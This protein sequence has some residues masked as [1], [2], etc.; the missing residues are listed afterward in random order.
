MKNKYPLP[1]I[2]DLFD[3]MR[4]ARVFSNIDLRSGYHQIKIRPSDFPKADFSTRYGLYEFT[5]MLF[6]LTNAPAHFMNLMNKVFI[7]YLDRFVVV[8]ID[9]IFI[10]SKSDSDHEEHLRLVLQKLRDNQLH[11]KFSKCEFWIG[12]VPFLGH[13]ISNGGISVD[14]AKVKEIVAWSIPTIVTEVQSFLGLAGYYR[15]FIEGLSKNSK[16]MTSLLEKGREFKLDEKCQD[17]FDQLKKRLMSPPVLVMPDLQKGFDIY[18]DACGQG[19]GCVLMQEGH[20]IAYASRQLWKHELNYPTHDLELAAV[21]HA[22]KIWRHYI[23]GT[24]CQ[25]YKYH[26]SLKYIFTRK[27]LNLRQRHWLELIKDY[28][29]EIHYHPGKA[30]LVA[31][32]LSWKEHVHSAIV[33]RLPE[34]LAKDFERLNLGIVTHTEGVTIEL[35]P[36]LEQEI[37]K[38]QIGD[39][40]IQDIKDLITEG[41][42]LDFIEDE[43]GTIWFKNRICVP[44]IDSLRE[45]ILK[46]AHDSVYSIHPGSTKMYQDLKQKYWWCGL[47]RVERCGCTCGYVRWVSKS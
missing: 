10:Y 41:R 9:D 6:G 20:V 34:E 2:K 40:K 25:V 30:N 15:R 8:F 46:E 21:V 37:R 28:D 3:Q 29:L 38:G 47:K 35:E 14:P 32:A 1:R 17:S 39:A 23:M 36:T 13:I 44:D 12:E 24:K 18:C 7:E 26:K 31:D 42:G 33:V 16:P 27:D 43:Q 19:L 4:G 11:A 45:T 5:V 22:L